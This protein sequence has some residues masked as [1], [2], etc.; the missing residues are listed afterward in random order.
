MSS[1]KA[2]FT[3]AQ[4]SKSNSSARA[5]TH[6]GRRVGEVLVVVLILGACLVA[7]LGESNFAMVLLIAGT[8]AVGSVYSS[9]IHGRHPGSK[10]A[11]FFRLAPMASFAVLFSIVWLTLLFV[12][13]L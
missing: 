4:K 8:I 13:G 10:I 7:T 11:S 1:Q 9:Q 6:D 12:R 2:D 3:I 5:A